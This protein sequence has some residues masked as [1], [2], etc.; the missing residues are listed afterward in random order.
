[1]YIVNF[2]IYISKILLLA[3]LEH[4][5]CEACWLN[6]SICISFPDCHIIVTIRTLIWVPFVLRE[7]KWVTIGDT[8]MKVF[9][10]VPGEQYFILL[11]IAVGVKLVAWKQHTALFQFFPGSLV[12]SFN[13]ATWVRN[14]SKVQL[15]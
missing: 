7:K 1:M 3:D 14:H 13:I 15:K 5:N 9:K 10:W 11:F 6:S 12:L 8:T 2:N 4:C